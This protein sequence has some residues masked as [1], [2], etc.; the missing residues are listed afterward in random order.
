[1]STSNQMGLPL[2]L[3]EVEMLACGPNATQMSIANGLDQD[4]CTRAPRV[5]SGV[6]T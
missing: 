1:M 4:A 6:L 2:G 3:A 5:G